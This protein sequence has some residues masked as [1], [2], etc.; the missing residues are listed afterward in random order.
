MQKTYM[1]K[2]EDVIR[3]CY[4]VDAK[5]QVL[6]RLAAKVATLLRGKHKVIYTP[7]VDTGDIVVVINADKVRVTGKKATDKLYK[8]HSG[9][10]SGLKLVPF[11]ELM[12][13]SP[14]QVIKLA[15]NRMIP[16]G[17]LGFKI[18]TRLKVYCGDTHPH[19]AQNPVSVSIS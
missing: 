2:P 18:R 11:Q 1:A 9:F 17:P 12:V 8:K 14:E 6:G 15:V 10:H 3:K 13:K 5:D 19:L 7:H 4:V 16:S